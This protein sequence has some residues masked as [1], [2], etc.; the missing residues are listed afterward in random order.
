MKYLMTGRVFFIGQKL[1]FSHEF[2]KLE[3]GITR[4]DNSAYP[5]VM[6]ELIGS[7]INKA[8]VLTIGAIVTV[9]FEIQGKAYVTKEG[10]QRHFIVLKATDIVVEPESEKKQTVE[11]PV[12]TV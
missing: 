8:A 1:A 5:N 10:K 3:F 9:T 6:F 12:A 2:E 7:A 4:T 11:M